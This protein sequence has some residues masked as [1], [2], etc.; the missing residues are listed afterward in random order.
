MNEILITEAVDS[1]MDYGPLADAT[2]ADAMVDAHAT[3][4]ELMAVLGLLY[5]M[6]DAPSQDEWRKLRG[7]LDSVIRRGVTEY[8]VEHWRRSISY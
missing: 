5:Q 3:R 4:Q 2:L 1:I 8:V 6:R 7:M